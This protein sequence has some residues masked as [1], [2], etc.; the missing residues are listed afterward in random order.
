M[1]WLFPVIQGTECKC[2]C[3]AQRCDDKCATNYDPSGT[4]PPCSDKSCCSYPTDPV[5]GCTDPTA[6]N[7]NECATIDD[8]SCKSGS[9]CP[10]PE[11]CPGETGTGCGQCSNGQ[12]CCI[13]GAGQAP[14]GPN[15][16][17]VFVSAS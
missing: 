10:A 13:C 11:C 1:S 7:Y 8:N 3:P 12:L 2:N 15:C 16:A 4:A 14:V 17:C 6:S 9:R 5:R